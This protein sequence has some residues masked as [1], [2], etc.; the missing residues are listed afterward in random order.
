[1]DRVPLREKRFTASN[2]VAGLFLALFIFCFAVTFTLLFRP[3]YHGYIHGADLDEESG[4]TEEQLLA[5]YEALIDY[6][7]VFY[8]GELKLPNMELTK[9]T[10]E[11]FAE[12]KNI[13]DAIQIMTAA[14]LL[15]CLLFIIHKVKKRQRYFL[16]LGA[17]FT[18]GI[19]IFAILFLLLVGWEKTFTLFHVLMFDNDYW[20]IDPKQD[21][22]ITILPEGYFFLCAVVIC[23]VIMVFSIVLYAFGRRKN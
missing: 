6:N 15:V 11:H 8:T 21:P 3:L 1:V 23:A 14:S 19:A 13:F 7:T 22:I 2:V 4:F 18:D 12:V 20:L 10:R 5:D 16:W 17:A 9:E